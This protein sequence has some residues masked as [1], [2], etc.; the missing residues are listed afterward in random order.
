MSSLSILQCY[1]LFFLDI[2]GK[3]NLIAKVIK[4]FNRHIDSMHSDT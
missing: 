4:S 2:E 1:D 3:F